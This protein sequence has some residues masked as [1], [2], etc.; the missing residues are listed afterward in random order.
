[1]RLIPELLKG[2]R[3]EDLPVIIASLGISVA[4]VDK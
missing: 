1:M 3:I 4:E 2:T